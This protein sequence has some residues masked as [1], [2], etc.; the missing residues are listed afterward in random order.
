MEWIEAGQRITI[1]GTSGSGKTTLARQ[2]SKKL[3]IP[4][5]E[6]DRLHWEP[7]WTEAP[8]SV[9]ESRVTEA[10]AGGRWVVDGNYGK[11][12]D[13]VWGRADT[14]VW[15]D[16]SF[17]VVMKQI[18]QRTIRRVALQ[19]ECCN[20]NRETFQIAF[21]SRDSVILWAL[22]TYQKN[23]EKYS[24]LLEQPEYSHLK[25]IRLT[26]PQMAQSWLE[27][28]VRLNQVRN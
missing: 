3:D 11:I 19:E 26:S 7:N 14:V 22:Q 10:L 24:F 6:L 27:S 4:H 28:A 15:L 25:K 8:I 16:Y 2:I 5:V 17:W 18:V 21:L 13:L 12:R 1:V 9:F 23:R 20:G